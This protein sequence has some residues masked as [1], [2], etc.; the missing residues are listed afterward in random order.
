MHREDFF[1]EM[2]TLSTLKINLYS[3]AFYE[4]FGH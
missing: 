4:R 2:N 1:Y 3:P